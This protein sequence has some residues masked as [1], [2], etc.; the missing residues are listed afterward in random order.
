[1][2]A[3]AIEFHRKNSATI[4]CIVDLSNSELTS[5]EGYTGTFIAKVNKSDTEA[6]IT[7]E[8]DI[9]DL[10]ITF[11]LTPTETDKAFNI[12]HYDI[13]IEKVIEEELI[14]EYTVVQDVLE[15]LKSV[16]N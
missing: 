2:G 3:N 6:V 14:N 16:S 5:L 7:K 1:M 11:V 4:I 9:I 12:Y 8:G 13:V 10:V 15:I